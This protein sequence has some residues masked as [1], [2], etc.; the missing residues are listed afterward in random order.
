MTVVTVFRSRLREGVES[1]YAQ[2]ASEMSRLVR[3][4]EGFVD[5]GFFTS[6]NGERVTIVRFRDAASQRAW[7]SH[8]DH[9]AAQQR[10][11][12]EFY[13]WYDISVADVTYAR[14]YHASDIT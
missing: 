11:R 13:E 9:L 3:E 14:T 1:T 12:D 2:V 8:P 5:E 7:A 6:S 10:G 4:M